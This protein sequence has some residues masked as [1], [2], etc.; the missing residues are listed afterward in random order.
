MAVKKE[1]L[2]QML[3]IC[4]TPQIPTVCYKIQKMGSGQN[5]QNLS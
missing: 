1:Y 4:F 3:H 2:F 5:Q